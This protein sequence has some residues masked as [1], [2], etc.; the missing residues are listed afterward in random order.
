MPA[1]GRGWGLAFLVRG[2]QAAGSRVNPRVFRSG[3]YSLQAVCGVGSK[4]SLAV[5]GV[6]GRGGGCPCRLPLATLALY[7]EWGEVLVNL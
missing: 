3:G 7:E 2:E 1:W 4:G 6:V 5:A